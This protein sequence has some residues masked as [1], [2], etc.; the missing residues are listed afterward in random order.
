MANDADYSAGQANMFEF[1]WKKKKKNR[2]IIIRNHIEV[3]ML[4]HR[5]IHTQSHTTLK[6]TISLRI[7]FALS[8]YCYFDGVYVYYQ[9]PFHLCN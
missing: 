9:E 4:T 3:L 2:I 6:H 7:P 8:F 1:H 5:H